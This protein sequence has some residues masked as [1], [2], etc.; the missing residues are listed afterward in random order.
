MQNDNDN[1]QI[2]NWKKKKKIHIAMSQLVSLCQHVS[3]LEKPPHGTVSNRLPSGLR[4]PALVSKL[5]GMRTYYMAPGTPL[6][7]LW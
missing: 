5:R 3:V 4:T 1:T 7:T 2:Q 6:S